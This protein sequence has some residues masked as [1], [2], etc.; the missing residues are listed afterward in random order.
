MVDGKVYGYGAIILPELDEFQG[1]FLTENEAIDREAVKV[2]MMALAAQPTNIAA[3][4]EAVMVE[5]YITGKE[6][7][8]A[9]G[10]RALWGLKKKSFFYIV[11]R[12]E[13]GGTRTELFD[14]HATT[15]D[16]AKEEV[17][18]LPLVLQIKDN[19]RTKVKQPKH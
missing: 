12:K 10:A 4:I 18:N 17:N 2:Q 16:E 6:Y 5:G 19:L 11:A 8:V 9:A 3:A 15:V 1:F 13:L 7:L 14:L